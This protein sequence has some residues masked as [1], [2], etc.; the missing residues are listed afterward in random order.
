MKNAYQENRLIINGK[1][2]TNLNRKIT[3]R[4]DE[5]VLKRNMLNYIDLLWNY[6]GFNQIV[7]NDCK[8]IIEK[9]Q[10]RYRS[11]FN[12]SKWESIC[13]AVVKMAYDRCYGYNS[14]NYDILEF[15]EKNFKPN[16]HSKIFK[17]VNRA[18]MVLLE[19]LCSNTIEYYNIILDKNQVMI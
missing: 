4:T 11:L 1:D 18:Y 10:D 19:V 3:Q 8:L 12:R 16:D 14:C 13:L 15:I 17:Q 7:K 5:T 6:Y 9:I 2:L